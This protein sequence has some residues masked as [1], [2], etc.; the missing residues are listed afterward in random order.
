M[1][2]AIVGTLHVG[3]LVTGDLQGFVVT[4][5]KLCA[6]EIACS[7]FTFLDRSACMNFAAWLHKLHRLFTPLEYTC[8]D[9]VVAT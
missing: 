5:H 6:H 7:S 2:A 3:I 1:Q 9:K 8:S 4:N